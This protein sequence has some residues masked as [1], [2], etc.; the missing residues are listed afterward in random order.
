MEILETVLGFSLVMVVMTTIATLFM[1]FAVRVLKS[2]QNGLKQMLETMFDEVLW[3]RFE[4]SAVKIAKTLGAETSQAEMRNAFVAKMMDQSPHKGPF[5]QV[6][7]G[8]DTKTEMS[9]MEFVEELADTPIGQAM[10]TELGALDDAFEST[11]Q[12]LLVKYDQVADAA[13]RS[14]RAN[15]RYWTLIFGVVTAILFAFNPVIVF[16]QIAT[17]KT[18]RDKLIAQKDAIL[19]QSQ[20]A[21]ERYT[22]ALQNNQP[23]TKLNEEAEELREKAD[24]ALENLQSIGL[25][26]GWR[27]YGD[28][29]GTTCTLPEELSTSPA[30]KRF[31]PLN[32]PACTKQVEPRTYWFDKNVPLTA[33]ELTPSVPGKSE[34]QLL[35]T[36]KPITMLTGDAISLSAGTV[37]E[38]ANEEKVFIWTRSAAPG[39]AEN[40]DALADLT[41]GQHLR[42]IH[43]HSAISVSTAEKTA[44]LTARE[45]LILI[46]EGSA[47][48]N[49]IKAAFPKF[50]YS[51]SELDRLIWWFQVLLGGLLIGLGGPFWFDTV[52][53]LSMVTSLARTVRQTLRQSP[54]S[55][56]VKTTPDQTQPAPMSEAKTA[57]K[58]FKEVASGIAYPADIQD[59]LNLFQTQVDE[60]LR[61]DPAMERQIQ[62]LRDD[63][64]VAANE[65]NAELMAE[66]V[67]H[68]TLR[69]AEL[70]AISN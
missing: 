49:D 65:N 63:I 26:I 27:F 6:L 48:S 56:D 45:D 7:F 59:L 23:S 38:L 66:Q 70:R 58:R 47:T 42:P 10:S 2:R 61:L 51:G 67:A 52:R 19:E 15:S 9:P 8:D 40:T 28:N 68:A 41:V 64:S 16:D 32:I 55:K 39:A 60:I 53:K 69:A 37:Y 13:S 50:K 46:L 17:E 20:L 30:A 14:F 33:Y 43:G 62:G 57:T 44:K 24:Q 1:E 3:P 4:T 5:S 34:S 36:H 54:P 22:D 35:P 18:V 25:S 31:K 11:M 12:A 29:L 21:Q